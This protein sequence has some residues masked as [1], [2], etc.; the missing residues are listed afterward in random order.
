MYHLVT[1]KF[2]VVHSAKTSHF[3]YNMINK[4]LNFFLM[5]LESIFL[6]EILFSAKAMM[7]I[8]FEK[9]GSSCI[10]TK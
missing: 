8:I 4:I 6:F 5:L 10:K 3:I 1:T 2:T 9:V 7:N